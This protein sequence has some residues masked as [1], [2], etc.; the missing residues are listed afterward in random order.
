MNEC[1]TSTGEWLLILA[2]QATTTFNSTIGN[3][4][5]DKSA[6]E[7]T[8]LG[9]Q[10]IKLGNLGD[11][12]ITSG[13]NSETIKSEYGVI[14][15]SVSTSFSTKMTNL[16][17]L[18]DSKASV[19]DESKNQMTDLLNIVNEL[20]G[21]SGLYDAN[22]DAVVAT[23]SLYTNTSMS[24]SAQL[25]VASL[26]DLI[27]AGEDFVDG[28]TSL[29]IIKAI[30]A[31]VKLLKSIAEFFA[32]IVAWA[33]ETLVN[34]ITYISQGPKEWYNGLILYGYGAYNTPNRTNYKKKGI[35]GY[36]YHNIYKMAGGLE[37]ESTLTG[38]LKTLSSFGSDDGTSK[39]FKGA[40]TEYLLVGSNSEFQNQSG[41]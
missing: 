23:S 13:W 26:T 14:T 18:L 9:N 4:F 21:I 33:A 16:I 39:M 28:I 1:T 6:A 41:T 20:L 29:N 27:W 37:Q 8:A 7:I 2:D 24:I 32:S 3:D 31:V 15:T 36:S 30:K 40:E 25:S 10:I 34:L 5:K 19:D 38:S 17:T 12:T 22:L 35:F 11:K